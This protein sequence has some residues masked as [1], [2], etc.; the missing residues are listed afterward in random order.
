[1]TATTAAVDETSQR[2]WTS[3]RK[4][5]K[6]I[7]RTLGKSLREYKTSSLL[8]PAFVLVEGI[9]EIAIPTVMAR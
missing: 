3:R 2:P 9:L 4:R 7:L 8:A 6:H 1:M 5:P